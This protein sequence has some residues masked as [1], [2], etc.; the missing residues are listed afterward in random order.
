MTLTL[1]GGAP[2]GASG[3]AGEAFWNSAVASAATAAD[4]IRA[5]SLHWPLDQSNHAPSLEAKVAN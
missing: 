2:P 3:G 1:G 4:L 5:C